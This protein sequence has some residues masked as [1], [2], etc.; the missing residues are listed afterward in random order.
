MDLLTQTLPG[1]VLRRALLV[2]PAERVSSF[3]P[4][5]FS[6][7]AMTLAAGGQTCS[8]QTAG[9]G[10]RVLIGRQAHYIFA[11]TGACA[12]CGSCLCPA[13]EAVRAFLALTG[14]KAPCAPPGYFPTP[15]LTCPVCHHGT[16]RNTAISSPARGAGWSCVREGDAHYWKAIGE[17][18][19]ISRFRC[20]CGAYPFPHLKGSGDCWDW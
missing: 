17:A 10:Y 20:E 2:R 5:D 15:P 3:R 7:K 9:Y 18:H 16:R 6:G 11:D 12:L 4:Q 14:E 8:V 19:M 1:L 13:S